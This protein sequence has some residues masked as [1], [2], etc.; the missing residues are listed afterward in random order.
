MNIYERIRELRVQQGMSQDELAQKVGYKWRSAI[1]KVENGER[2]ISQSM[3]VKY[4]EALGV[5]PVYL[6]YGEEA[7][8]EPPAPFSEIDGLTK[9]LLVLFALL[10]EENKRMILKIIK[11]ILEND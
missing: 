3:I 2:D 10:S 6:L 1:S 11:G 8:E 7:V 9:E 5:T 4:A